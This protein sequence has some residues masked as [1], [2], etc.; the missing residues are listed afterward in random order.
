MRRLTAIAAAALILAAALPGC[1]TSEANYR[2]AY[3]RAIAGRDSSDGIDS[4]V[5]GA[6]RRELNMRTVVMDGGREQEVYT[7]HVRVTEGG[8]AIRENLRRYN[9]VV[10]RF[11]QLFNARSLRERLVEA[12]YPGAFVVETAEPYYFVVL[13]S[14]TT[15][16]DAVSAMEAFPEDVVRMK[17]PLPFVLDATSRADR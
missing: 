9:V 15:L 10:G 12:G 3:E 14:H 17:E 6:V 1:K 8:G 7:Q 5:Y 13:S 16:P 2:S 11:K 4:T